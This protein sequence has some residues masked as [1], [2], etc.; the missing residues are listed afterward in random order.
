MIGTTVMK[1]LNT[2]LHILQRGKIFKN[3]LTSS[4]FITFH[5]DSHKVTKFHFFH[6]FHQK[7]QRIFILQQLI[8]L[9]I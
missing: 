8:Y 4:V 3:Y 9:F 6:L 2:P 7:L 1:G 5:A